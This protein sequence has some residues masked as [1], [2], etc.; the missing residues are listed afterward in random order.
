V[1]E[2]EN[3]RLSKLV[4]AACGGDEEALHLL[5]RDLMG[6]VYRL[7]LRMTGNLAD[8]EDATQEVMIKVVTRLGS[9][10]GE[11][12]VRTWAYRI[13][14][15]QL[16]DQKKGRVESMELD[17]GRFAADLL[18]GLAPAGEEDDPAA[19][20]EVKLGCT[21]AMLTCLD[22]AHRVAYIL[23]E[24]F[25]LPGEVAA[26]VADV[27]GEVYRQ[28]LSRARRQL[29]AFTESY[30]GIVNKN[31]PCACD[32]RVARAAQLG[33][34]QRDK[35]VLAGQSRAAVLEQ[36]REIEAMHATAALFRSHPRYAAPERI[37]EKLKEL[38]TNGALIIG[39]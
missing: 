33:R 35:L 7:A 4:E 6:D 30:C 10:R 26:A 36:V 12:S 28:R 24:V 9:F 14:V 38:L 16:L 1:T 15:R 31:A 27:S 34:L 17:F 3:A 20:E 22:R 18:E 37:A 11:A 8:A 25:D 21:L 39:R 2:S 5:V 13:A 23:G 32:R 19:I 29:E